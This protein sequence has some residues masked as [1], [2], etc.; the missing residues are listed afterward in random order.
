MGKWYNKIFIGNPNKEDFTKKDLP[1]TRVEQ[2]FDVVKLRFS[3]MITGN[4]IYALFSLPL[5]I[6]AMYYWF[7]VIQLEKEVALDVLFGEG[8]TLISFLIM[9]IPLYVIMGPAKAGLYYCLR[10][11]CWNERATIGEHFWKE[12]KRSWKQA[13]FLNFL[14]AGMLF[15][16]IFWITTCILN[17]ETYPILQYV[18]ILVGFLLV[19]YF[20]SSIYHFPQLVTYNL[21][22]GQ[23]I[24][25]SFIYMIVQFP[26]T[27]LACVIYAL[28]AILCVVLSQ[29]LMAVAMSV[30][31]SFVFLG[32]MIL[33]DF[34]FDKYVNAPE[35]RRK[36]L[37]PKQ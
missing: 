27:L 8:S 16:G 25:N 34:L 28:L 10:N 20:M 31:I 35:N 2:F 32:Q 7:A 13:M 26:R 15:A 23:I 33:S 14:N 19:F 12:F 3:G 11:W 1:K 24:K 30:G 9:C 36:G 6:W 22:I 18:A 4:L 21:K 5:V 17:L 29:A 37:A